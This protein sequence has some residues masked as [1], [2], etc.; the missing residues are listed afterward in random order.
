MKNVSEINIFAGSSGK[1]FAER[2]CSYLGID[3]KPSEVV[4]F[5]E[6]NTYVK[7]G[8]HVR[9]KEIFLIQ[10]IALDANN[11][12]VE[13]LF[14]LD[15]FK[16]SGAGYVTAVIPYFSYAKGD[17]KDEPRVSIRARVC[18]ESIELA[19]AD[20]VIMM[21]LHAP[22]IQ[23]F[24]KKPVDHLAS[25][26]LLTEYIKSLQIENGVVVAPDSGFAKSA[27]KFAEHLGLPVAIGDK[28][29]KGGHH[30]DAEVLEL[31]G[32]VKGKNAIV[33]DD[34]SITG[35]TL[36][37]LGKFIKNK[38][39]RKVYACLSHMPLSEKG[40]KRLEESPYELIISTDSIYNKRVIKSD[41]FRC[42]S[43]APLF[44]EAVSRLHNCSS[45]NDLFDKVSSK[46]FSASIHCEDV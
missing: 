29:R 36:A 8:E 3:L 23:G 18:A 41:K 31:I 40:V 37:D 26:P 27:R 15:A 35:G 13:L 19:G 14:W 46:L 9:G 34:F 24:F 33:V 1:V 28:A 6:G 32:N 12:L 21:D 22:Q 20:R 44:A 25:R 17:K 42:I 43:V 4:I 10:P 16:R 5:A 7:I 30:E 2:M 39:A 11:E 38:G 45:L